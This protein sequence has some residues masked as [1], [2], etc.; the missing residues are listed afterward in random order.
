MTLE[1]VEKLIKKDMVD[2]MNGEKL[3]DKDIIVLQRV[4]LTIKAH[5]LW[6]SKAGIGPIHLKGGG[7]VDLKSILTSLR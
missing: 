3:T 7:R 6:A 1:C 4:R 5:V 2:P